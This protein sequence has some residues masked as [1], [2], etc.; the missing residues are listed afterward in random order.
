MKPQDIY[1]QITNIIKQYIT[2]VFV[3]YFHLGYCIC[4]FLKSECI[5]LILKKISFLNA[6]DYLWKPKIL[7]FHSS[8]VALSP[9]N[10][11]AVVN[12]SLLLLYRMLAM[13]LSATHAFCITTNGER[14]QIVV[15]EMGSSELTDC[16]SSGYA[17][18]DKPI[19]D[20]QPKSDARM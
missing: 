7:S 16:T 20:A 5:Y 19:S 12:W 11:R 3:C 2:P 14:S 9:Q 1:E 6:I 17:D 18:T 4:L 15:V 8:E 13:P 10:I